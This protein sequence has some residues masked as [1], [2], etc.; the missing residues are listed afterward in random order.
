[1]S[2][3]EPSSDAVPAASGIATGAPLTNDLTARE[4]VWRR[5]A[6]DDWACFD[7]L[8]E[9]VRRRM[10]DHAYD[11]WAVNAHL[12]WR[13]FRRR[14]ASSERAERRLLHHLDRCEA[15]ERA[16]FDAAH[17]DAFDAPL[18]H[19]GAR[20]SVLRRGTFPAPALA[21]TA[22]DRATRTGHRG[23]RHIPL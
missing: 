19:V 8:P 10:Q 3:H 16:A 2:F 9:G 21:S 6:G 23:R 11:P 12:L 17:R 14:L 1:M 5:W 4:G 18:P 7:A 15:L 22:P 13:M 20:A